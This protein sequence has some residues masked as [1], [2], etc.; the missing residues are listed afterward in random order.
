MMYERECGESRLTTRRPYRIRER[1]G[2]ADGL[3]I[4]MTL[5]AALDHGKRMPGRNS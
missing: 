1:P 3:A 5:L 4:P 2:R